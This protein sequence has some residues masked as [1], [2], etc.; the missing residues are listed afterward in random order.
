[1]VNLWCGRSEFHRPRHR[2][3]I[4]SLEETTDG[5]QWSPPE[6]WGERE[7]RLSAGAAHPRLTKSG[8]LRRPSYTA[9]TDFP[10]IYP[11]E[12]T[13]SEKES[14]FLQTQKDK[15]YE[16]FLFIIVLVVISF[17]LSEC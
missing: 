12:C 15:C 14:V 1:M 10:K 4:T 2:H 11:F 9:I 17:I 6:T 7:G 3:R 16:T 13:H 5:S 8:H